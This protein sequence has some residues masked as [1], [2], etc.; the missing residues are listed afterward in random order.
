MMGNTYGYIRVLC[1]SIE[2]LGE[3]APAVSLRTSLHT[4]ILFFSEKGNRI[5]DNLLISDCLFYFTVKYRL[6]FPAESLFS[7]CA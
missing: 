5:S 3:T 7:V 2:I 6:M 4:I 1:K